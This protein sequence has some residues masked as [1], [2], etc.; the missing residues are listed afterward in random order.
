MSITEEKVAI[1]TEFLNSDEERGEKLLSL[2]PKVAVEQI[3][4]YGHDFT[5]VELRGYGE[6]LRSVARLEDDVLEG[7]AGGVGEGIDDFMSID[8]V[9][10]GASA[11]ILGPILSIV[12][13]AYGIVRH[14]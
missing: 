6:L 5:E 7:V 4:A 12:A 3:N 10:K 13:V 11:T 8:S 9:S 2:E 14:W 1:L